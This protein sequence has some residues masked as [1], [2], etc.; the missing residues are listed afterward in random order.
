MAQWKILEI[1]WFLTFWGLIFNNTILENLLGVCYS[2][3]QNKKNETTINK[4]YL[5][6]LNYR[7]HAA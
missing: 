5:A 7:A 6:D 1:L 2:I 4:S 3:I